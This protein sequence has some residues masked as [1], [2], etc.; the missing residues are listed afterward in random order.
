MKGLYHLL[1]LWV[2]CSCQAL[3]QPVTQAQVYLRLYGEDDALLYWQQEPACEGVSLFSSRYDLELLAESFDE[4]QAEW[5]PTPQLMKWGP[6]GTIQL[7]LYPTVAR[8]RLRVVAYDDWMFLEIE[9]PQPAVPCRWQIDRLPLRPG[10]YRLRLESPD[11]PISMPC[12]VKRESI[13][14]DDIVID[15]K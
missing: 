8:V 2:I 10:S 1:C 7:S 9:Q 13:S 6:D 14:L 15:Q 3:A 11:E 5:V 12:L 4:E